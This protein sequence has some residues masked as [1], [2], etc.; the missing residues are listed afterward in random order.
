V[1]RPFDVIG[2]SAEEAF[3]VH[4]RAPLGALVER[5]EQLTLGSLRISADSQIAARVDL[6]T[7]SG[8]ALE[9][10]MKAAIAE[11]GLLESSGLASV[12]NAGYDDLLISHAA[13]ALFP[14]VSASLGRPSAQVAP[15]VIQRAREYIRDHAAEPI[16]ISTLAANL[17]I[18][19]RTLQDNFRRYFGL[20][21]QA[22]QRE[23]R[24]EDAQQAL[25]LP[26]A[27]TTVTAVAEMCGFGNLGDFSV[28]YRQKYG[29]SPSE[30]LRL[31]RKRLS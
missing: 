31:A 14:G 18:P 17:G 6:R 22:W 11:I 5:A 25:R 10:A 19:M 26:D 24:L 20:S 4:F 9:R 13:A 27:A 2:V 21:P 1:V 8:R 3:M 28:Q 29:E 12:A 16:Y 15:A 23:C 7:S 30:T